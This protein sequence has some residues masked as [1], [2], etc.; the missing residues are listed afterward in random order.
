MGRL[1]A[2]VVVVEV[3]DE[4]LDVVLV[5][6]PVQPLEHLTRLVVRAHATTLRPA[7]RQRH[8]PS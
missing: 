7:R 2:A 3:G 6:G 5:D 1:L 4:G 8:S